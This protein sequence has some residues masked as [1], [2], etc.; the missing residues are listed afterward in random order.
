MEILKEPEGD[1][2]YIKSRKLTIEEKRALSEQIAKMKIENKKQ[3]EEKA[4]NK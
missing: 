1:D 2:F 4:K 3:S